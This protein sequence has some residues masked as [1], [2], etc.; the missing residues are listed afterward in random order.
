MDKEVRIRDHIDSSL[1][2]SSISS[3]TE[4]KIVTSISDST[5]EFMNS[6]WNKVA[7]NPLSCIDKVNETINALVQSNERAKKLPKKSTVNSAISQKMKASNSKADEKPN[8]AAPIDDV[9]NS[10]RMDESATRAIYERKINSKDSKDRQ[11]RVKSAEKTSKLHY[12]NAV[13]AEAATDAWSALQNEEQEKVSYVK[14]V[15]QKKKLV[16]SATDSEDD[17]INSD[18]TLR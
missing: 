14:S 3:A 13:L 11:P 15:L 9:F 7:D 6:N 16:A 4:A 5:F 17:N 8:V 18:T 10:L 12:Q 2:S 1:V